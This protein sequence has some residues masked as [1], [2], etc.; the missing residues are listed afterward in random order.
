VQDFDNDG[1]DEAGFDREG[2][3]WQG[4]TREGHCQFWLNYVLKDDFTAKDLAI[5]IVEGRI[6]MAYERMF[7]LEFVKSAHVQKSFV[8][9]SLEKTP[10]GIKHALIINGFNNLTEGGLSKNRAYEKLSKIFNISADYVK[11]IVSGRYDRRKR[12]K[13]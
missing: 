12:K 4:F 10:I 13:S 1:F 8:S 7:L 3:D 9:E 2:R 6:P 5:S 11:E